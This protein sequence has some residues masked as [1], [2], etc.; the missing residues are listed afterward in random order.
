VAHDCGFVNEP[1]EAFC[2]GCGKALSSETARED[3][4]RKSGQAERRQLTVMFCDLVGSTALSHQLDPEDLREVISAYQRVVTR[5][6]THYNGFVARYMGDGMLVY[7]GYP[8]AHEDDAVRAIDAGLKVVESLHECEDRGDWK[9]GIGLAVRVG[10]ATGV[11]VVGD[12]IGQGE[13]EEAAV[14]GRTPNLAARLQALAQPDTV[15]V[16]ELTRQLAGNVFDYLDDGVHKL[17]GFGDPVQAWRV[18]RNREIESRFDAAH[19]GRLTP[20]VGRDEPLRQ[21]LQ[22]WQQATD[23]NGQ[24]IVLC[25]EAGIGKSRLAQSLGERI[26]SQSPIRLRYQC[27]PFYSNSPLHPFIQQVERAADLKA[28][29]TPEQKTDKLT[30]LLTKWEGSL[31]E[32]VPLFTRLLSLPASSRHPP[33]ALSAEEQKERIL[34]VLMEHLHSL[35]GHAPV[36]VLIEDTHWID[37]TSHDLLQRLESYVKDLRV[38]LLVTTRSGVAQ[39]DKPHVCSLQLERL[40]HGDAASMVRRLFNS[41][42]VSA[43]LVDLIIAKADGVP[44]FIEELTRTLTAA[45]KAF[46]GN[47]PLSL[48]EIPATLQ[49]LLMARLDQLGAAKKLAQI[50]AVIGREFPYELLTQIAGWEGQALRGALRML[51]SSSIVLDSGERPG[52]T[53]MFRHALLQDAAYASL[54]RSERREWHTRIAATLDAAYPHRLGTE[55]E[56]IAHHYTQAGQYLPAAK[57]WA[58][59]ARQ[60]LDRSANVETVAHANQ[61]AQLL[62]DIAPS[63]ERDELELRLELMRGTAYRATKGFASSEV[64]RSFNRVR[65][66]S[67]RLGNQQA[68]IDALRGLFSCFYARGALISAREQG[69]QVRSL[70]RELHDADARMLGHWMLGCVAFWQGEYPTARRELEEAFGLYTPQRRRDK[71]LA[72]QIDPGVNALFHLSCALW[73]LGYPEQAVHAGDK[74]IQIARGLAQPFGLAMALFFACRTRACCG[75]ADWVVRHLEELSDLTTQHGLGYLRSCTR[76]LEAE[77]LVSQNEAGAALDKQERAFAEFKVQQAGVALPWAMSISASAYI[78]LGQRE[79]GLAMI[80]SA[81]ELADRS[82]EHHWDAELWRLKGELL[83]LA[84]TGSDAE[85]ESCFRCARKVAQQQQARSLELR[86]CVALAGLLDSQGKTPIASRMVGKVYDWFS[87]GFDTGDLRSACSALERWGRRDTRQ[88]RGAEPSATE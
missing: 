64:E 55:P 13:S 4:E 50:A 82:G 57:F 49:D 68:R 71:M 20:L 17:K 86:A 51:T 80:S 24:F 40:E 39:S 88:T 67:E 22:R 26:A 36:L 48:V 63:P 3:G 58:Q 53:F 62:A 65:D 73:V 70:G 34:A 45:K 83:R 23:G 72:L 9:R 38:L 79:N 75:D 33:L 81:M 2:G 21:L 78:R 27:S 60:A 42:K 12:L 31:N 28:S 11:V 25:G 30:A 66:L 54:L 6:I 87:E 7:F 41:R 69:E 18:S 43:G 15:V 85:A 37:P 8:Y 1:T 16:S 32:T 35:A 61:G 56:V 84:G 74:A 44:L 59:A 76:V 29:D 77:V 10:I 47:V 46:R 52:T 19:T 5:V 14:V